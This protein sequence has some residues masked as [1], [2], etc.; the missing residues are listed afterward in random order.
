M[1]ALPRCTWLLLLFCASAGAAGWERVVAGVDYRQL[2][3]DGLV[4][5]VVRIDLGLP[6]LE[7]VATGAAERGLTVS[8][9]ARGR[10]AVVAINGDY[11]DTSLNPF[12]LAMG[13][14]AVWRQAAAGVRRQ[15]VLGVGP[16]RARIFPRAEPLREPKRW[17]TGAVAGWPLVV[18][19]CAPVARLPGS[20]HFTLAPHPR[21]AV[22]L[23]RDRRTLLLFV[24]DGRREGVPGLTLPELAELMVEAGACT[25]LNLDGGGSSA[26]WLRDRIVNRPSDGF[27]RKV[28][29]HLGV[30]EVRRKR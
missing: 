20:A 18:E 17:M 9:F 29:N 25:A 11:F 6:S 1:K 8:D 13:D 5:H 12:G 3:R 28:A 30:V 15:E 10:D 7:V 26:L 2:E 14:G 4:A 27:E 24:A 22:G 16:G 23:S 19:D 21:T